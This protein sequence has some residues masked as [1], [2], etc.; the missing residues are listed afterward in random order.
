MARPSV[1]Q[2]AQAFLLGLIVVAVVALFVL[3]VQLFV[4]PR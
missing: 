1:D 4:V 2:G 3:V